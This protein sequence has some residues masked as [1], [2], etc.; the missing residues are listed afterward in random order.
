MCFCVGFPDDPWVLQTIEQRLNGT[1]CA[2]LWRNLKDLLEVMCFCW[3][4]M[5]TVSIGSQG[6]LLWS[7]YMWYNGLLNHD[8]TDFWQS[9]SVFFSL[10]SPLGVSKDRQWG[11]FPTVECVLTHEAGDCDMLLPLRFRLLAWQCEISF[12]SSQVSSCLR[13]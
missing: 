12:Y 7:L 13:L 6:Y 1:L 2:F 4:L 8:W 5:K 9:C 10:I 11:C 3:A